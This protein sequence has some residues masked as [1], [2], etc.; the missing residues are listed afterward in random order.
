MEGRL[1]DLGV[2]IEQLQAEALQPGQLRVANVSR[3]AAVDEADNARAE[4]EK[5]RHTG[6]N[7]GKAVRAL[8][9]GVAPQGSDGKRTRSTP[10]LARPNARITSRTTAVPIQPV[11]AGPPVP[12]GPSLPVTPAQEP[13]PFKLATLVAR[14]EGSTDPAQLV[15]ALRRAI[16]DA[17]EDRAIRDAVKPAEA[18]RRAE[19]TLEV[20]EPSLIAVGLD[21]AQTVATNLKHRI[22]FISGSGAKP[23]NICP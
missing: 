16:R 6:D 3:D 14:S 5:A 4:A 15:V 17:V 11:T 7:Q 19:L 21:V 23:V 1:L 22:L 12:V 18:L 8:N 9:L 10:P 20:G 2:D 13:L